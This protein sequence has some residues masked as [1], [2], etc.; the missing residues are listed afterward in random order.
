MHVTSSLITSLISYLA[1]SIKNEIKKSTFGDAP[2]PL[3]FGLVY[4]NFPQKIYHNPLL[5]PYRMD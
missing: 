2:D 3:I 1:T 4:Q 5:G